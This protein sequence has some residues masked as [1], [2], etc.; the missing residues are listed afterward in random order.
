MHRGADEGSR[1]RLAVRQAALS[2]PRSGD[3]LMPQRLDAR[4]PH[5]ERAFGT[6][7]RLKREVS[8]DVDGTVAAIIAD[9]VARGDEAVLDYTRRF[10]GVDLAAE[11]VRVGAAELAAATAACSADVLEPLKLAKN[12][13]E[14]YHLPQ[15]PEDR[16]VTDGTGVTVGWRWTALDSVGLYV[17]GGTASY[18]SSVLMNAIPAK[19]AGVRRVVMVVPT[20]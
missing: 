19:V 3:G 14:A 7:L 5:F 16:L 1:P 6:L 17:P 8:E 9:V 10:D 20:P 12:R 15:R 13:I 11:R 4:D 2:R 18:P